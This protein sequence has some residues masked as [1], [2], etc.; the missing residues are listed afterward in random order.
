MVVFLL[1]SCK[2]F[3]DPI[4][5]SEAANNTSNSVIKVTMLNGDEYIYDKIEVNNEQNFIGINKRP[6]EILETP[7]LN[8]QI[9]SIQVQNKK[10]STLSNV[11]G[12]TIGIGA[13]VLGILM[14]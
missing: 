14:L 7:L 11:L 10:S 2:V 12:F 13:V 6:N 1:Q 4:S 5:L 9:K 8:S 3:Q